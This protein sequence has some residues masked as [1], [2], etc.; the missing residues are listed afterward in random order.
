VIGRV[1]RGQFQ[2]SLNGATVVRDHAASLRENWSGAIEHAV[3]GDQ[4]S[5][6]S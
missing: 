1:T 6:Q 5:K 2:L 3:L 4:A